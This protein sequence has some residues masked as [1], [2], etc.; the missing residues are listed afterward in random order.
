MTVSTVAMQFLCLLLI[1]Q[2]TTTDY[3]IYTEYVERSTVFVNLSAQFCIF[4]MVVMDHHLL[5]KL[6]LGSYSTQ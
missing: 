6:C 2:L 5:P 3:I 4:V 1:Y